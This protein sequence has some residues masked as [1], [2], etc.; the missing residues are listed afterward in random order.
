[1]KK[2]ISIGL[3]ICGLTLISVTSLIAG[4]SD[5]NLKSCTGCH[6]Q[7]FE[8]KAMG[9]SLIVYEM[10]STEIQNALIGY[11]ND[12]YGGSM[13]GIMKGQL[14]DKNIP[15]I[16]PLIFLISKRWEILLANGTPLSTFSQRSSQAFS[17]KEMVTRS[18]PCTVHRC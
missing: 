10:N 8:K 3:I 7:I 2:L 17:V 13:K 6:G 9:K 14:K 16:G 11:Q 5:I 18:Y 1:M 15:F 4:S 12:T